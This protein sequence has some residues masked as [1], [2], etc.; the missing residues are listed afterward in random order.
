[1]AATQTITLNPTN[2]GSHKAVTVTAVF[3]ERT[4]TSTD[5]TNNQ[6]IIDYTVK[7]TRN[8]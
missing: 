4:Q 3:T 2:S 7:L 1:M 5:I 6:S 8:A